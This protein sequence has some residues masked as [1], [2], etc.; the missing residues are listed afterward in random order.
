M[1]YI[2]H[3]VDTFYTLKK[4][5]I[6]T[7]IY[8]STQLDIW[9]VVWMIRLYDSKN[10]YFI[11][12]PNT[13]R[14]FNASWYNI[15]F[16]HDINALNKN[17]QIFMQTKSV[18][19]FDIVWSYHTPISLR[20]YDLVKYFVLILQWLST[21]WTKSSDDDYWTLRQKFVSCIYRF[22]KNKQQLIHMLKYFL[23]RRYNTHVEVKILFLHYAILYQL[24][25]IPK[26]KTSL[27]AFSIIKILSLFIDRS[28][29]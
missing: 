29:L 26:D 22:S 24:I 2:E 5:W 17:K 19:Y 14:T 28:S 15:I 3:I 13:I 21:L 6:L 25:Y 18:L 12:M 4:D 16:Y 7:Y 9:Y 20:M 8:N 11:R 10:N 1:N 27:F 23:Y